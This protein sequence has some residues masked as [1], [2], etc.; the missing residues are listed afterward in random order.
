MPTHNRQFYS[1]N[2]KV[3]KRLKWTLNT[4]AIL[5]V[6]YENTVRNKEAHYSQSR[7]Y[8]IQ[9]IA[10]DLVNNFIHWVTC[11]MNLQ[12]FCQQYIFYVLNKPCRFIPQNDIL[13]III[14]ERF[15]PTCI[16][17][18]FPTCICFKLPFG[19]VLI[20]VSTKTSLV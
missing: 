13:A 11:L 15:P 6:L 16:Y 4:L 10:W 14:L 20:F 9:K 3:I 1:F 7:K 17:L 5:P 12:P 18:L 8:S 2:R 19:R